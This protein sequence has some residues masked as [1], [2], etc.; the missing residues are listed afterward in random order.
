MKSSKKLACIRL[1]ALGL[2][3]ILLSAKGHSQN[4]L[5][6]QAPTLQL[7]LDGFSFAKGTLDYQLIME[8]VAEKQEEL[9]FKAIQNVFLSKVSNAGGTIYSFTNNVVRELV[10][11]KDQTI[12]TRK[13]LENTVNLVFVTAYLEYFLQTMASDSAIKSNFEALAKRYGYTEAEAKVIKSIKNL[14]KKK[15]E[16]TVLVF[17]DETGVSFLSLLLDMSSEAVRSDAKLKQLGLMQISYSATYEYLNRYRR[18]DIDSVDMKVENSPSKF[19]RMLLDSTKKAT[20]RIEETTLRRETVAAANAVYVDMQDQ[21]KMVTNYIGLANYVVDHF[22]FRNDRLASFSDEGLRAKNAGG[23]SIKQQLTDISDGISTLLPSLIA[24]QNNDSLARKEIN[25]L[26]SIQ[27]YLKKA[28]SQFSDSDATKS[29]ASDI[30]YTLYSQFIPQLTRQSYRDFKYF[31]LINKLNQASAKLAQTM[32]EAD[33]SFQLPNGK[34]DNFLLIAARLYQFDR[35]AT[36][37]EYLKLVE[38]IGYIFPDDRV[39]NA[40]SVLVSFIKDYTVTETNNKGKEVL[41]FDLESFLVKL[42]NVKPYKFSPWQFHFTVGVNTG[43]FYN[44]LTL[45]DG[46]VATN[47][48]YVGEKIG[49]K[50]KIIDRGFWANRNPGDTYII[51]GKTY[52]KTGPPIEPIISNVHL[53]VYGTGLLYMLANTKTNE[54]FDSPMIGIGPGITFSNALDLNI[55]YAIPLFSSEKLATSFD[56]PFINVGFDI[57]FVEYYNRMREKQKA[58]KTQKRLANAIQ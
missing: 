56:T 31:E 23:G 43:Y 52:V 29:I 54:Q 10:Q 49:V 20:L 13:I 4:T 41:N 11:E 22:S 42:A 26:V 53:L 45:D 21:L 16:K 7:G 15:R 46:S 55:S 39:K 51:R 38:E 58:N 34:V 1:F 37:S 40:L 47:L 2:L 36:I 35:A 5:E 27:F 30:L 32:L 19:K 24:A 6:H 8:I 17:S 28:A 14:M 18:L 50:Y 9:K 3:L 57:Q 48:S 33:A 44:P 25:N 12:R